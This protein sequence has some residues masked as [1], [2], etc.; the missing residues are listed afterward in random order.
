M[1]ENTVKYSTENTYLTQNSITEKTKNVWI[2]LHGMGYL[3]KYFV[4]YFATLNSDENYLIVPQAPSKYYLKDEFKY[5]GASWLTKESTAMEIQNVMQYLDAVYEAEEIPSGINLI[6]FGF[7]QGVSIAARWFT[8][9]KIKCKSLIL[10]AGGIPNE[11][12]KE[13]FDFIDWDFT[14][15][16]LIYGDKDIYITPERL[17]QEYTKIDLLFEG[18]ARVINFEGGHEVKPEIIQSLA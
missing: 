16:T 9:K 13:D 6:L 2:I 10:Y 3:S 5:V 11:L 15:V 14:S 7:S 4:K 12:K 17:Q 8:R 18:K 1:R